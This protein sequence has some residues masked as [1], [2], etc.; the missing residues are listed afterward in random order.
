MNLTHLESF[1]HVARLGSFTQAAEYLDASKGL[2]SRHVNK[3]EVA[4]N[5]QLF[6]RTTRVIKLTEAGSA[7]FKKAEQIV[8][9]ADTAQQSLADEL[10]GRTG[11]LR[12]T[13]PVHFGE[14]ILMDVMPKFTSAFPEVHIELNLSKSMENMEHG[15]NDIAVRLYNRHV[16][17]DN[18]VA[19]KMGH[20]KAILVASPSYLEQVGDITHAEQLQD[21]ACILHDQ[22][23]Q[24]DIYN[25]QGGVTAVQAAAKYRA[26]IYSTLLLLA[27]VGYGV[28]NVP[29]YSAEQA[30]ASGE[31]IH[32]L[33]DTYLKYHRLAIIHAKHRQL[34]EKIKYFKK[35]LLQW[36]TEHSE[37]FVH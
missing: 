6:H 3:L 22:F 2:V 11:H 36:C 35:L 15:E 7:L 23:L 25:Q 20:I 9:L 33:P 21:V 10:Y 30:L 27:R 32:V 24:L 16:L 5:A 26:E 13:A 14:R 18:V 34:P 29:I 8:S 28:A 4:L 17:P 31:L 12:F 1:Y 37:Y 19:Q